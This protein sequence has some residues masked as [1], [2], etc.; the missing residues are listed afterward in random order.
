MELISEQQSNPLTIR[1]LLLD[2]LELFLGIAAG[3]FNVDVSGVELLGEIH[4]ETLRSGDDDVASSV[5]T[6]ELSE[7]L[8]SLMLLS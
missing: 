5:V 6:E 3:E 7:D 4:L 2:L 8:P 1:I